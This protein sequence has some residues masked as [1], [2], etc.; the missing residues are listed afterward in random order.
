M[1]TGRTAVGDEEVAELA[2]FSLGQTGVLG[3]GNPGWALCTTDV[4]AV[5]E[6]H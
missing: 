5:Q 6:L 1:G 3:H 2:G 4:W